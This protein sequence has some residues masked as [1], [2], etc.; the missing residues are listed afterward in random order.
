MAQKVRGFFK[1]ALENLIA[2]RTSQIE[3]YV[4]RTV[5]GKRERT[6]HIVYF[7]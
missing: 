5:D 3:R 6:K 7:V 2:Y 1:T 4:V